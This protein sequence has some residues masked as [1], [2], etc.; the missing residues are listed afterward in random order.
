MPTEKPSL[1]LGVIGNCA[2]GALLDR[3]ARIVWCCL[4]RFDG[5]PV[6]SD[7]MAGSDAPDRHG[8]WAIELLD[9]ALGRRAE[10]YASAGRS[11]SFEFALIGVEVTVANEIV[12]QR[13]ALVVSPG[14]EGAY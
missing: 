13:A 5:D 8:R 14:V 6:F 12:S 9:Q 3:D 4:P 10:E 1:D 7:L 2:Y 11:N